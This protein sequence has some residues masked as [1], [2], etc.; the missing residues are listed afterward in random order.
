MRCLYCGKHL[1]LLRKLTGGGEFC[2]DAHRDKYH[3]EYNRL[4][5]SRL[6]QA[7]SRPE[8]YKPAH[9][10]PA[11]SAPVAVA[12]AEEPELVAVS[13]VEE[14][15]S[16]EIAPAA[17]N[18]RPKFDELEPLVILTPQ[19]A[20]PSVELNGVGLA[21][22]PSFLAFSP[23]PAIVH[24][25][26]LEP[27]IGPVAG[28]L[29]APS[30]PAEANSMR[31]DEQLA[32]DEYPA[33]AFVAGPM[34]LAKNVDPSV[35]QLPA[36]PIEFAATAPFAPARISPAPGYQL[37]FKGSIR[38]SIALMPPGDGVVKLSTELDDAD[39]ARFRP[40]LNL[41]LA[42]L[43]EADLKEMELNRPQRSEAK[44]QEKADLPTGGPDHAEPDYA[45]LTEAEP[46]PSPQ[47]DAGARRNGV[48]KVAPSTSD[49]DTLRETDKEPAPQA[50]GEKERA[51]TPRAAFEALSRLKAATSRTDAT[52][53]IERKLKPLSIPMSTPPPAVLAAGFDSLPL[54]TTPQLL[55]Y[56]LHP[57][58][59]K[60]ALGDV[61][62]RP[63]GSQGGPGKKATDSSRT[64]SRSMLH[65]DD[66]SNAQDGETENSSLLGRL[67]GLFGKKPRGS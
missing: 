12:E 59:P 36:A 39:L 62:A 56:A 66:D 52:P 27:E 55:R 53:P 48:H 1:P 28:D 17:I 67:G 10:T 18:D 8:D 9:K 50:T 15:K 47:A 4:A 16:S 11:E 19:V 43:S 2:S 6:L 35:F 42:L 40:I 49:R 3:E 14:F 21:F 44:Q 5:V 22:E 13:Y 20:H 63:N 31:P 23:Q 24:L 7:Q 29:L 64:R 30:L 37:P 54:E 58:R 51:V 26:I 38:C 41:R 65:L 57:L 32:A 34:P 46:A 45:G 33:A 25:S 61:I 60:M